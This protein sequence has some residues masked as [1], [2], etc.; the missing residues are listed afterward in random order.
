MR[1]S[2]LS[3]PALEKVIRETDLD[4]RAKTPQARSAMVDS[5]L[6]QI[7]VTANDAGSGGLVFTLSY[8][9]AIARPR[10]AWSRCS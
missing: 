3:R 2:L 8:K 4:L 1:Q 6:K 5:L 10:C 7:K 9:I